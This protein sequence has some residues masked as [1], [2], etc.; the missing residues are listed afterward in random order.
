VRSSVVTTWRFSPLS[1]TFGSPQDPEG[2]SPAPD[3]TVC[4]AGRRGPKVL[5][6]RSRS[7]AEVG[8]NDRRHVR[9][10]AVEWN[11]QADRHPGTGKTD[12]HHAAVVDSQSRFDAR[13]DS[14]RGTG[15]LWMRPG[16]R[17]GRRGELPSLRCSSLPPPSRVMR[18][19][20]RPQRSRQETA[21]KLLGH[22][23]R[24]TGVRPC[25]TPFSASRC[26]HS[27]SMRRS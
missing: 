8:Q 20:V 21:R 14:G 12:G 15:G 7:S 16:P 10:V 25:S 9:P 18:I 13:A 24:R 17:R 1:A 6:T 4:R 5:S 22:P 11:E 27:S 26:I 2:S 3:F 23:N 19:G